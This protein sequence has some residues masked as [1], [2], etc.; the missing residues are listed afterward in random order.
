[1]SRPPL[2]PSQTKPDAVAWPLRPEGETFADWLKLTSGLVLSP[3]QEWAAGVLDEALG[4]TRPE[5]PHVG[6]VVIL[7]LPVRLGKTSVLTAPA[8][9]LAILRHRAS[10]LA[11]SANSGLAESVVLPTIRDFLSR[12]AADSI[13]DPT[14]DARGAFRTTAGKVCRAGGLGGSSLTGFGAALSIVDDPV[15]S[16]VD[17]ASPAYMANLAATLQSVTF[18]RSEGP[19][20]WTVLTSSRQGRGD[21]TDLLLNIYREDA[22][23]HLGELHIIAAPALCEPGISDRLRAEY[24]GPANVVVH[25]PPWLA[26]RELEAPGSSIDEARLP[27]ASLRAKAALMGSRTASSL[28][29]QCPPD[30]TGELACSPALIG[31]VTLGEVVAA[32]PWRVLIGV[33]LGGGGGTGDTSAAIAL[34]QVGHGDAA[35]F[36][37]LRCHSRVCPILGTVVDLSAMAEWIRGAFDHLPPPVF[38]VENAAAGASMVRGLGHR[39]P[40]S[41]VLENPRYSKAVRLARAGVLAEQGRL[42]A[43][44][45]GVNAHGWAELKGELERVSHAG[46]RGASPGL[47]DALSIAV[48]F[49]TGARAVYSRMAGGSGPAPF[50]PLDVKEHRHLIA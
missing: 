48:Q 7:A 3:I 6:R 15:G 30:D 18:S 8:A 40:G 26:E 10:V 31:S 13:I 28:L 14:F 27:V 35:R 19:T 5:G 46:V 22:G 36:H 32:R 39:L 33:D 9:A 50:S 42:S 47:V 34:A 23:A 20:Y 1:M 4:L 45:Q 38:V 25:L 41:A 2:L 29:Q 17:L 44:T 11:F 16:S 21:A 24:A 12:S 43:I 49:A 37:I